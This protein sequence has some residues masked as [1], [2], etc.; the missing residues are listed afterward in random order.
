MLVDK[1]DK[2]LYKGLTKVNHQL[3]N[4]IIKHKGKGSNLLFDRRDNCFQM[5]NRQIAA[6]LK[7][8]ASSIDRL[9][10]QCAKLDLV[11]DVKDISGI[12]RKMLAPY[13][14]WYHDSREKPLARFIYDC[15][16]YAKAIEWRSCCSELGQ[17]ID[18]HTGEVIRPFNWNKIDEYARSYSMFDRCKRP[19]D[20]ISDEILE[21]GIE[22]NYIG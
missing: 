4:K 22:V 8:P 19:S 17:I 1:R 9:F 18:Y 14:I 6:V 13:F 15:G 16:S 2:V 5:S 21:L 7:V 3:L 20:S 11:R 12:N 10:R